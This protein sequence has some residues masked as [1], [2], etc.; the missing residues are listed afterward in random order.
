MEVDKA[1]QFSRLPTNVVPNH[2]FLNIRPDISNFS[3][4]G[5]EI[6]HVEVR[7]KTKT[8]VLNSVEIAFQSA[9]FVSNNQGSV[10]LCFLVTPTL[11]LL[12]IKLFSL[13]FQK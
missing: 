7:E 4:S 1:N 9:S 5:S 8:I 6:V 2:Y 3:F 10:C 12:F 13:F 11:S